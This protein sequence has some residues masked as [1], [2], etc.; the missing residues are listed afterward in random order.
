MNGAS[1]VIVRCN[2]VVITRVYTKLITRLLL[3]EGIM[4]EQE[5]I[6]RAI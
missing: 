1:R 4:Y 6:I 2:F 5:E 3:L